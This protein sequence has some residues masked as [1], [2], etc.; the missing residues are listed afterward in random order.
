M[1]KEPSFSSHETQRVLKGFTIMKGRSSSPETMPSDPPEPISPQRLTLTNDDEVEEILRLAV[2][3]SGAGTDNELRERLKQSAAELNISEEEL[4]QAEIEFIRKREEKEE[5][6]GKVKQKTN[7]FL[8]HL[9]SYVAVNVFL[10]SIDLLSDG[11]LEWSIFPLMGWGIGLAVHFV[12][13][14]VNHSDER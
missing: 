7:E 1:P 13:V 12:R 10:I 6:R 4:R 5:L 3:K 2:R 9:T 11:Q 14:F 8:G